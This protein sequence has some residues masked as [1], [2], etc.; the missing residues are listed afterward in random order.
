[1]LA[2]IREIVAAVPDLPVNADFENAYADAPEGV[3]R[4]VRLCAE[5]GVAGLSVEDATGRAGDPLYPEALAVERVIAARE[6]L[7]GTGV[8]L[9]ARAEGLLVGDPGGLDAVCR[10]VAAFAEAGAD[11][12]YA[13]AL[14]RPEEMR[15][16]IEAAGGAPVN[17]LV[18]DDLGLVVDDIA[19]LGGR[20]ISVGAA[21]ARTAWAGFI[22]AV[23]AIAAAGD[24]SVFAGNAVTRPIEP[25]FRTDLAERTRP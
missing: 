6:A 19:A 12:L 14:R 23:D 18:F 9:T 11:V 16:V 5:T 13:P 15:A 7:A 4:H 2:H 21:L 22:R 10:R 25:F 1:M 8:V 3:A 20:R 17:I 24:F